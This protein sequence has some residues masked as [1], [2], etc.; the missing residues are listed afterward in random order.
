MFQGVYGVGVQ[1]PL[2]GLMNVLCGVRGIFIRVFMLV[3]VTMR[4]S[5]YDEMKIHLTEALPKSLHQFFPKKWEKVGDVVVVRFS[6]EL[7]EFESVVGKILAKVLKCRS[8][9]REVSTISGD[10]RLP[11]AK[12][13]FGDKNSETVHKE[14]GIYF[15][16]DPCK[17][18]FSSGNMD[19]RIRMANIASEGEIVVDMFAGIGYFS[20]PLAVYS[21]PKKVFC[22]ELNPVSADFLK[23]NCMLNGVEDC[24]EIRSGD[25]RDVCPKD[26]ADRVLMGFFGGT[27]EFLPTAFSALKKKGGMLHFHEVFFEEE[28]PEGVEQML[29]SGASKYK[30]NL[31]VE[32]LR[33]V[34]S[35]APRMVHVVCDCEVSGSV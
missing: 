17:V 6:D 8:V 30:R 13:I 23:K 11:D 28:V 24:V 26:V 5:P 32:S 9:V 22:C 31:V 3:G 12:V 18:M 35:T 16:L 1:K 33:V 20:I 27:K 34:K 19:E 4:L 14:N 7:S 25:C 10:L 21:R 29:S 15:A 2:N